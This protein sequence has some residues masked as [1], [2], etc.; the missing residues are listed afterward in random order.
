[1]T[2]ANQFGSRIPVRP[3]NIQR[4]MPSPNSPEAPRTFDGKE[5]IQLVD[6][7]EELEECFEQAGVT[8]DR[9]KVTYLSKYVSVQLQEWVKSLE[10]YV[11]KN[12]RVAKEEMLYFYNSPDK[13]DRYTKQDLRALVKK[14][15]E[16]PLTTVDEFS[17]RTI[18]FDVLAKQLRKKGKLT[19]EE[20][21][22]EFF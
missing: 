2:A 15:S 17:T 13:R 19:E 8:A 14:Y 10:G 3:A 4:R 5:S 20:L 6:F 22:R 9:E 21:D 7:F 11:A 1:M 12:Y 16:T 18:Q